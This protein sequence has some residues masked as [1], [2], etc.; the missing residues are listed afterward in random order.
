MLLLIIVL[1]LLVLIFLLNRGANRHIS[2]EEK[3]A[4]EIHALNELNKKDNPKK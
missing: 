4:G 2:H 1:I 3:A